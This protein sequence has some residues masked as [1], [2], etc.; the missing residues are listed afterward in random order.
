MRYM[1][2]LAC[3]VLVLFLC[4]PTM[5][6]AQ[7]T[8]D[9][10]ASLHLEAKPRKSQQASSKPADYKLVKDGQFVAKLVDSRK[11]SH[12]IT[13]GKVTE[14]SKSDMNVSILY[15]SDK[16]TTK[17]RYVGLEFYTESNGR[18][19][20]VGSAGFDTYGS[21]KLT[22]NTR[23]PKSLYKEQ[24]YIYMKLGVFGSLYDE[25]YSAVTL[26]K[27]K[28]PFY[29]EP[30]PTSK[31]ALVSNE[32]VNGN[33][34]Q[35]TGPF[36]VN[37]TKYTLDKKLD[38]EAYKIDVVRPFD[39]AKNKNKKIQKKTKGKISL[40]KVGDTK[41]FWTHDFATDQDYQLPATLL[42]SGTKADVWVNANQI[43]KADAEKLGKEFEQKI[44][45]IVTKNF[46]KE[47]D[48]DG[49]GKINILCFDIKD[50]FADSGGYIAGY[51]YGGDLFDIPAS[52][53]SEIFYMDTYPAMGLS[54]KKD[55][56]AAYETLAHE[57]QHMVN[58]N[59]NVFVENGRPMD[60]WLDEG[61][62]MAAE[63]IYTGKVLSG[64]I[65]YYN[66]S[67]SITNGHSLLYWDDD[68]DVLAN[69]SLS[70]LFGQF[71][72]TQ[73]NQGNKIFAEIIKDP[74]S[75]Y[76][77]VE[78][79]AKKYMGSSMTFG[80]LMTNFRGA[81]FLK[82]KTGVYGF[83]GEA[84]FNSLQQKFFTGS[85]MKLR[86][87]G[88]VVKKT[89]STAVPASKGKDITYTFFDQSRWDKIPPK[90]PI[91]NQVSDKDKKVTGKAEIRSKVTV[92]AGGKV[93]GTATT[94][95]N[96]KFTVSLKTTRKAGT[97][98]YVTATDKAKNVSAATKVTVKDK[99]PPA[100]PKVNKVTIKSISVKGKAE[101]GSTV[102]VKIGKK[103][104]G[105]AKASKKGAFSVKIKKQKVG[106]VLQVY[107]K[108]RAGNV[109]KA[110][111]VTV[112]KK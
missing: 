23:V 15:Q 30:P 106:T 7:N 88:A 12:N 8:G 53:K 62:A 6:S 43:T 108:D 39:V 45:S 105:S 78:N 1:K 40:N 63:H 13:F 65:N 4:V 59:Q 67:N 42:Y 82:E 84:G 90:K 2:K 44:H 46:A 61:L 20:Y 71:V 28:N 52:N 74:N 110:A 56:T 91:V 81:L 5:I 55:V 76:K 57:F 80:K 72:R 26:F 24:P 94:A 69:Y 100:V 97:V 93:I 14:K 11:A 99:T 85:S 96:G 95:S 27:V 58:F 10:S 34:T 49:N 16:T 36:K 77:A 47:S 33:L 107:A 48:V 50:G 70:Y 83:K 104:V 9:V 38:Q 60:A 25:Y 87:G 111:K 41:S 66:A 112:K 98:L 75:D 92:K 35:P 21:K 32:S 19:S 29:K 3:M 54:S 51:F 18:T 22:L 103:V 86:G 102:Y 31:V 79:V 64:R 89:N 17:D 109:G 37:N 101:A 68:G 73:A